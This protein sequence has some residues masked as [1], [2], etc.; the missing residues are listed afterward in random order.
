MKN[1][2]I[3]FVAVA[4][5]LMIAATTWAKKKETC[6]VKAVQ[7]QNVILDCGKMS[8]QLKVDDTV[9]VY[10]KGIDVDEQE[11]GC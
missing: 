4:M 8:L 2:T 3:V 11:E 5:S 6:K 7:Q 1:M 10:K 9:K